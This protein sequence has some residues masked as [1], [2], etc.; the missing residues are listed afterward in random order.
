[1]SSDVSERSRAQQRISDR[2][3]KDI[4]VG[5]T[6]E[7]RFVRDIDA[8]ENEFPPPDEAMDIVPKTDPLDG[9]HGIIEY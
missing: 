7:A 9:S 2:M 1:M 8:A 3:K 6:L 5:V 4:R